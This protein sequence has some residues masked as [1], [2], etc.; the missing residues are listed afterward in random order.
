MRHVSS[1]QSNPGDQHGNKQRSGNKSSNGS[2]GGASK[3]PTP[4]TPIR[5][6]AI[7]SHAMKPTGIVKAGGFVSRVM[8]AAARNVNAGIVSAAPTRTP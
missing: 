7:Q 1:T 2:K 8:S 6:S 4:M 5:A 3:A